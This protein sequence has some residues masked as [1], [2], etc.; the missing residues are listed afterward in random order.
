MTLSEDDLALLYEHIVFPPRVSR[1]EH[2]VGAAQVILDYFVKT[3]ENFTN[4]VPTSARGEWRV[5]MKSILKWTSL[6]NGKSINEGNAI[7]A[8]QGLKL[9]GK[10]TAREEKPDLMPY[11]IT[12][13]HYQRSKFLCRSPQSR[14]RC[15]LRVF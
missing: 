9:H 14:G 4:S 3:V 11:R 7:R 6:Y 15:H 8:M 13:F 2:R 12:L 1:S 5:I 10:R